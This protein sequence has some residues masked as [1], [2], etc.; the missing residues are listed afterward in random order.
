[1]HQDSSYPKISIVIPSYNQGQFIEQ[2]L[3]SVIGQQYP[4]LE[5]IV[6]DGGS[7]DQTV[8]VVNKYSDSIAHFICESDNGQADA[9]N[10]GFRLATGDILGWLNS[11][12]MYLPCTLQK[13]RKVLAQF[14]E[15][16]LLYGGCLHFYEGE[17]QAYG[18]LPLDFDA[19][20]LI[21]FDYI[22]QPSTFWTRSLWEKVGEIN[23]SYNYVLDWEWFI[24]ASKVCDFIPIKDYLSIYRNHEN[25][26][27][28]TGSWKRSQEIIKVVETYAG[29]KWVSVY[30]DVFKKGNFL[31]SGRNLLD[32]LNLSRWNFIL[33]P[34]LCLKY[35]IYPVHRACSML[36]AR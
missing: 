20:K 11:D 8:E 25:H 2:T 21:Q 14:T 9:I 19:S 6:I 35:G 36:F 34:D 31:K 17:T 5:L 27:T 29:E 30:G 13:V 26:K 7:T 33:C 15:P 23:D 24:R 32:K 18:Y 22:V 1:M 12:D 10:K 3:V 16:K 4:N 28:G